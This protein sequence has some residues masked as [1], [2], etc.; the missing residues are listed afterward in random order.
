[1]N[2]AIQSETADPEAIALELQ[3]VCD[4]FE[5]TPVH[6]KESVRDE[7]RRLR[8]QLASI[9]NIDSSVHDS[10]FARTTR[11]IE[12]IKKPTI[13]RNGFPGNAKSKRGYDGG[14]ANSR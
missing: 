14:V 1:M 9:T 12:P 2:E 3:T 4:R 7:L 10:L 8:S 6:E 11:L 5:E 13:T